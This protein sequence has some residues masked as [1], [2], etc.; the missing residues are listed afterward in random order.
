MTARVDAVVYFRIQDPIAS[1]L[2]AENAFDSTFRIAQTTL[3]DVLGTKALSELLAE[4]EQ[5]SEHMS[6]STPPTR[7]DRE[8]KGVLSNAYVS[9]S[10]F[11]VQELLDRATDIWGVKV[12]RVEMCVRYLNS[13]NKV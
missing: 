10:C 11:T 9:L 7:A 3:R 4:R 6:V 5:I 8:T 1:V 13:A 2:K 12:E